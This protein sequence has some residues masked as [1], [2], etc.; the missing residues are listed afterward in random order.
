M[1]RSFV[2]FTLLSIDGKCKNVPV[3]VMMTTE[4]SNDGD[5]GDDDKSLTG[6]QQKGSA[7]ALASEIDT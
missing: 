6:G 7:K 4:Q 2:C 3:S 5:G 1:V